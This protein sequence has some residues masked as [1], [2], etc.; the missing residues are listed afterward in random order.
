MNHA[1]VGGGSPEPY[2]AVPDLPIGS[3]STLASAVPVPV[4]TTERIRSLRVSASSAGRGSASPVSSSAS[5]RGWRQ[6]PSCTAAA[7]PAIASGLARIRAWPIIAAAC[8]VSSRL[9][10]TSPL[11]ASTG[12]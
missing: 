10:G 6:V 9:R 2:S 11:N 3:P 12:R 4:V 7:T 5:S 8:S 1:W